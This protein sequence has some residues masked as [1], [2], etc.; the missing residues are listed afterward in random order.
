MSIIHSEHIRGL[1]KPHYDTQDI[2]RLRLFLER[3]GTF[4]FP[5]LATGLFP[6]A[7]LAE[8]AQYTG[9]DNVWV[10]DNIHIAHAHSVTGQAAVAVRNAQALCLYFRKHRHRFLAI[11]GGEADAGDPMNRPHV[12]FNGLTLEENPEKWSH[13]QN[14]ALGY[15][16][17]LF[18][19]LALAGHIAPTAKDWDILGLFPLFFQTIRYW[20]DEDSGHWEE[21]RK[22]EA[23]SIGCVVAGLREMRALMAACALPSLLCAGGDV[24]Q[25]LLDDLIGQGRAALS[26]ILPAECVQPDPAKRR[27]YDAALLFLISPLQVVDDAM[28]DQIVHD[29]ET[30][31]EGDYGIRRYLGDSFWCADYKS[32]QKPE[33]RTA[34]VSDDMSGRDA[35]LQPGQEAQ[36]CVFDPVLSTIY[37][38]RYLATG[39]ALFREKQVHSLNRSLGQLTGENSR[40]P[41]FLCPELYCLEEGQ[42]VPNDVTPLLWTQANLSIA[43]EQMQKTALFD[44]SAASQ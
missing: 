30:H 24:T 39:D 12:R 33:A 8:G 9:Y 36:W 15:F 7:R 2:D 27:R 19:R 11:V 18:C 1:I 37:G 3:Q 23:S 34:D 26:Q 21:A 41:E 14:D 6:A 13:A 43:L 5:L 35:L 29:I 25:T 44:Q 32:L 40:F 17:W 42:Y 28:A 4:E 22:V 38:R 20:Q 10:R 16:L 31:L